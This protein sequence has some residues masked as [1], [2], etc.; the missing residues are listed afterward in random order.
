MR[1]WTARLL[2]I[3]VTAAGSGCWD[4]IVHQGEC[5]DT[6]AP[7]GTDTDADA[8]TDADTDTDT[9][10][11]GDGQGDVPAGW[12]GFG[13]ACTTDAD[14]N[15]YPGSPDFPRCCLTDVLGLI[16]APGGFCT[17]CCNAAEIGGC[18]ENIDCVGADNAYTICLAHCDSNDDCR[19]DEG[20]ECREIYYIPT[21]FPGT[22]CLPDALHK[23]LGPDQALDDPGC[24]WPWL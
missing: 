20:W 3:A 15:A 18:A 7:P 17:A 5:T 8:D 16:N 21:D 13:T 1:S 2:A 4:E 23:D 10:P 14:C 19:T 12:E 24:P 22:F 9:A 11:S 6:G